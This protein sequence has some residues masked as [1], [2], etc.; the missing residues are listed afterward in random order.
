MAL[1]TRLLAAEETT[2]I[3]FMILGWIWGDGLGEA[4]AVELCPVEAAGA[5]DGALIGWGENVDLEGFG[6]L[7]CVAGA[8]TGLGG[9]LDAPPLASNCAAQD[10]GVIS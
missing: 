6:V 7:V 4:E 3:L 10:A 1:L 2:P 9:C 8:E 5:A